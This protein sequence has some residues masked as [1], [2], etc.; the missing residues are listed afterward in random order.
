[1]FHFLFAVV[2][3]RFPCVTGQH[4]RLIQGN[5]GLKQSSNQQGLSYANFV[6]HKF[7]HLQGSLLDYSCEVVQDEE[8]AFACVDNAPCIS[9]NVASSP[10]ENGTLRCELLSED[11]FRSPEKLTVSQQFHHYSIKVSGDLKSSSIQHLAIITEIGFTSNDVHWE[12]LSRCK[13]KE[14]NQNG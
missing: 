1:M 14:K 4:Q 3:L 13:E 8:C 11:M 6:A 10:N 5:R 9:F 2:L 12:E 7:H